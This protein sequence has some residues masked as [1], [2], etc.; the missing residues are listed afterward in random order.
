M[1]IRER[2][3]T[4]GLGRTTTDIGWDGEDGETAAMWGVW[5]LGVLLLPFW[6][7]MVLMLINRR[8]RASCAEKTHTMGAATVWWV[9]VLLTLR[10]M[11]ML[12]SCQTM[13]DTT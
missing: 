6:G 5:M 1:S 9:I 7:L 13:S 4:V 10:T 11:L 2:G 3:V 12:I 8:K